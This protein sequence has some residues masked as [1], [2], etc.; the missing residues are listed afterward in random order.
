MSLL[1]V[2]VAAQIVV[3]ATLAVV[4]DAT[5]AGTASPKVPRLPGYHVCM[6]H[7]I[8]PFFFPDGLRWGF[9]QNTGDM[10]DESR[11]TEEERL[12]TSDWVQGRRKREKP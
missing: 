12:L 4:N 3:V 8:I 11:F 2:V 1:L 6:G 10:S 9:L 7:S 5:V